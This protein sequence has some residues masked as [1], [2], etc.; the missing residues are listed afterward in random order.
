MR[1]LHVALV[2]LLLVGCGI[3]PQVGTSGPVTVILDDGRRVAE[4][5]QQITGHPRAQG[6]MVRV[7]NRVTIMCPRDWPAECLAHE[8]R[9]VVEPEWRHE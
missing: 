7:G 6:C 5:C 1:R 3:S 9:H 2:G 8:V 4:Q